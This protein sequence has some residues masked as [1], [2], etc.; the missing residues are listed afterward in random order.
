MFTEHLLCASWEGRPLTKPE[1]IRFLGWMAET[2]EDNRS[3]QLTAWYMVSSLADLGSHGEEG[4]GPA[5]S[6]GD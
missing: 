5:V 1:W 4:R 2:K 6:S 3:R